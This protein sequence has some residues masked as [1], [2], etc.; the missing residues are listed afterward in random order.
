MKSQILINE[1]IVDTLP[2]RLFDRSEHGAD[3]LLSRHGRGMVISFQFQN[4]DM[5]LKSYHRGGLPG[6]LITDTY[7]YTGL[8]RSRMW[9]EFHLLRAMCDLGLP[10]PTP[11]AARCEK[12]SPF[13]YRG[14]LIM[15]RIDNASTLAEIDF[16]RPAARRDLVENR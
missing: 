9:R 15:A 4:L 12:S 14:D 11:I 7:L 3:A 1:E 10:V 5:V 8:A 13:T 16:A 6:R 2:D